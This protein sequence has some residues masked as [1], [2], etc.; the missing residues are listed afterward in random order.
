MLSL[1]GSIGN[2]IKSISDFF[3]IIKERQSETEIIKEKKRLE[4][5]V[6]IAEKMNKIAF[7]YLLYFDIEDKTDFKNLHTKFERY[8]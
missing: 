8:N 7:K 3:V 2:A 6:N 4:R 1:F 5:A